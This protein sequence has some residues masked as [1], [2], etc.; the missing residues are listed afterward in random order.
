ME[1]LEK[2]YYERCNPYCFLKM[3]NGRYLGLNREYLP[4]DF[5]R[6]DVGG[7]LDGLAYKA[8]L[9]DSNKQFGIVLTFNDIKLLKCDGDENMFWLY[10]DENAPWKSKKYM[11][12]Y[13]KKKKMVPLV[14]WLA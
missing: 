7:Y 14:N 4:I 8:L 5:S 11:E 3:P 10:R 9:E 1:K 12:A 13:D 6:K 2:D